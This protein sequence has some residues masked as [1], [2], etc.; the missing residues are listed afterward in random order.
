MKGEGSVDNTFTMLAAK[1]G[2]K[3]K[4][5]RAMASPK[6]F[7]FVF[8][9]L[10]KNTWELTYSFYKYLMNIYRVLKLFKLSY[11]HKLPV[12]LVNSLSMGRDHNSA[13]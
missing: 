7:C 9:C 6:S 12:H 11:A 2:R 13:F 3:M 8:V 10:F 5:E 1:V 4:S